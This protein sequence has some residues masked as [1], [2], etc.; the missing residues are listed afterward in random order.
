MRELKPKLIIADSGR[1]RR[2]GGGGIWSFLAFL[3]VFAVGVYVGTKLDEYGITSS[4]DTQKSA[5]SENAPPDNIDTVSLKESQTDFSEGELSSKEPAVIISE[6]I[7]SGEGITNNTSL[8]ENPLGVSGDDMETGLTSVDPEKISLPG[9][10]DMSENA[11]EG[12]V[13]TNSTE[14]A[15][16]DGSRGPEDT[17][18]YGYTLQIAAFATPEEAEKVV[19]E[20]KGKGYDAYTVRI[21]NSRGEEWNLVKIGRFRTIERAW[22]ESSL[23]KRREGKDAFVETLSQ[24]TAVNESW[25]NAEK[26]EQ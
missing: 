2:R 11:E 16:D 9:E 17:G 19:N 21:T 4:S 7:Q 24:D 20:Y 5:V 12:D 14:T 15:A 3:I 8:P 13:S 23:F 10:L 26:T 25:N 22:D 18:S 1:R 6:K